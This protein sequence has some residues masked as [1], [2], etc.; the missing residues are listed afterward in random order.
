VPTLIA[1]IE[2]MNFKHMPELDWSLGYPVSLL[3]MIV[4][5]WLLYRNFRRVGWL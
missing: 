3:I 5:D 4:A 1:G 2:G